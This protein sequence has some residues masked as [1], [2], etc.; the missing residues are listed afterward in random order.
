MDIVW[1]H[2]PTEEGAGDKE[3]PFPLPIFQNLLNLILFF[4]GN[5]Q[6]SSNI[7]SSRVTK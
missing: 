2:G 6:E 3:G 4:A 1:K 5:F 7:Y